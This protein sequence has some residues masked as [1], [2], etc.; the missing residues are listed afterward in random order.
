MAAPP[1][2]APIIIIRKKGGG[3]GG[4][5]GGA[6]KVAYADFV[7]A[8]MA[9]F[10]VMWL[11]SQSQDVRAAVASYFKDP[12]VFETTSGAGPIEGGEQAPIQQDEFAALSDAA[13][14]IRDEIAK[15]PEL[16]EL[17]RQAAAE[18]L[19]AERF[20]GTEAVRA[21]ALLGLPTS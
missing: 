4:H 20:Q 3:H 19:I 5:H 18:R 15:A 2:K 9:F 1:A 8:M 13:D 12:G 16:T 11:V 6:W 10:L 21:R 17:Q 14:R 7:T